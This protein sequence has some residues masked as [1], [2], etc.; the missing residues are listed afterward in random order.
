MTIFDEGSTDIV[1]PRHTDSLEP[2]YQCWNNAWVTSYPALDKK[3]TGR[4]VFFVET[5]FLTS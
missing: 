5:V 4:K 3:V 1:C 2:P